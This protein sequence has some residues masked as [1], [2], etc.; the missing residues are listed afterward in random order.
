MEKLVKRDPILSTRK[1]VAR[2]VKNKKM[3]CNA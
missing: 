2:D 3:E 1:E